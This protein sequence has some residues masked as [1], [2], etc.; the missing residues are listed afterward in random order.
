MRRRG[1]ALVLAGLL[2][3]AVVVVVVG[4]RWFTRPGAQVP[5]EAVVGAEARV[6]VRIGDL[7]ED[8][9][10]V[11]A[12]ERFLQVVDRI[13]GTAE[14]GTLAGPLE[15]LA[16]LERRYGHLP[17]GERR[18]W[19]P[20]EAVL[21]L[22]TDPLTGAAGAVAAVNLRGYT[23]PLEGLVAREA[24][25][26]APGAGQRGPGGS[27][28]YR[29]PGGHVAF[30]GGTLV[31]AD[32]RPRLERAL[33][34]LATLDPAPGAADG[35]A[36]GET[37][38][39]DVRV[40]PGTRPPAAWVG[41]VGELLPEAPRLHAW[42]EAAAA[43]GLLPSGVKEA[44]LLVEVASLDRLAATWT[45]YPVPAEDVEPVLAAAEELL[46]DLAAELRAAGLELRWSVGESDGRAGGEVEL[47][48]LEALVERFLAT[49]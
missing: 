42:L 27:T 44:A 45:L 23:R 46:A 40:L 8:P 11:A 12:F 13:E 34:R 9:G 1:V 35:P 30:L 47:R 20:R 16:R 48:G 43:E 3:A 21:V 41:R 7:A 18:D 19:L 2:V 5:A 29:G 38:A 14:P 37:G 6:V 17:F 32:E 28:I 26:G 10:A 36:A 15:L 39:I 33:R 49:R 31:V 25:R 24:A 4:V 22:E